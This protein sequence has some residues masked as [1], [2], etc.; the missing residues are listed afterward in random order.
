[1]SDHVYILVCVATVLVAAG[2]VTFIWIKFDIP[3]PDMPPGFYKEY[4][5]DREQRQQQPVP[6]LKPQ[7]LTP[8]KSPDL[9]QAREL[10]ALVREWQEKTRAMQVLLCETHASIDAWERQALIGLVKA[11]HAA[12]EFSENKKGGAA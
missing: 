5:R 11:E 9:Y 1:M 10:V 8:P 3:P 2:I 7:Q 4:N 6:K 12:W